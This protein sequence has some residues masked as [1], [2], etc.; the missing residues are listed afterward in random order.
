MTAARRISRVAGWPFRMLLL[1]AVQLYR[2]T[3]GPMFAGRCRFYPS[4]SNY[5]VDSLRTHGAFRGGLLALWRILRCSP[6]T[7]GGL[8]PV[9]PPGSWRP[10]PG[11]PEYDNVIQEGGR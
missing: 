10:A 5:A 6:L 8:D 11:P 7:A 3:L 4:C 2:L 1:G 9:P